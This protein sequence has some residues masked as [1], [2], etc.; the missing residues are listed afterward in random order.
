MNHDQQV[1]DIEKALS[2]LFAYTSVSQE[3]TR[4]SLQQIREWVD[5]FLGALD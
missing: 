3:Q 2:K 5:E 1:K 4:E